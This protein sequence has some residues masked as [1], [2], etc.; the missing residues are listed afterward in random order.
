MIGEVL[1]AQPGG[2]I[3][4]LHGSHM[5]QERGSGK[6]RGTRAVLVVLLRPVVALAGRGR[7][8]VTVSEAP[9]IVASHGIIVGCR[10][11]PASSSSCPGSKVWAA[12]R[13]PAEVGP[14]AGCGP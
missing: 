6:A 9:E 2:W 4:W 5:L 12:G 13:R 7:R 14:A 10:C 11:G 3:V 1:V 8:P